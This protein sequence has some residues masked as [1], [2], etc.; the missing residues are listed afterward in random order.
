MKFISLPIY[1]TSMKELN[2]SKVHLSLVKNIK[3]LKSIALESLLHVAG[4]SSLFLEHS[5][6]GL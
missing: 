6:N 1:Y 5:F 4:S 3:Q 2:G